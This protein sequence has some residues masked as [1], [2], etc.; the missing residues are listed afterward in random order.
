MEDRFYEDTYFLV[1]LTDQPVKVQMSHLCLRA[2]IIFLGGGLEGGE[3]QFGT[4][5][6]RSQSASTFISRRL[7][8][9][10]KGQEVHLGW[11]PKS[12]NRQEHTDQCNQ[13]YLYSDFCQLLLFSEVFLTFLRKP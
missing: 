11:Y 8:F 5:A 6:K 7:T 2:T 3:S 13:G 4:S 12:D 10:D 9:R 1:N